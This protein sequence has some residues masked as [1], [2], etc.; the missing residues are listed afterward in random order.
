MTTPQSACVDPAG[1]ARSERHRSAFRRRLA[2]TATGAIALFTCVVGAL[3][4]PFAG[5]LLRKLSPAALCPVQRGTPEQV[6]RAHAISA[7]AKA[8]A[9]GAPAPT[10]F[11]LGF[12]LDRTTRR[13]VVAWGEKNALSCSKFAGNESV[14]R[15]VDVPV[16]AFEDSSVV[17]IDGVG[18][19]EEVSFVFRSTGELVNVQAR[20]RHLPAAAASKLAES[21]S[22]R[23]EH[24][25]GRP[26]SVGGEPTEAHLSRGVLSTFVA[27]YAFSDYEATVAATNLSPH[28]VM[29]REQYI[30][31]R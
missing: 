31:L 26:T 25:F 2:Y 6:D 19:Y 9:N 15:C 20:R 23:A 17:S 22:V 10:R 30:S 11:A 18:P 14:M 29:V 21:M 27:E 12:E 4:M 8:N 5:S 24:A 7:A 3:H 13:D 16:K 1:R 28:G